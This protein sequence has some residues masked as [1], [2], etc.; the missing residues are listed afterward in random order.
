MNDIPYHVA[1]ID[2]AASVEF[3][4]R[5]DQLTQAEVLQKVGLKALS[6]LNKLPIEIL[7]SLKNPV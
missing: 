4:M 3:F 7:L 2:V 6:Q 5:N 1:G